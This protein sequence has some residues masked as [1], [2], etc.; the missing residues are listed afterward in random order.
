MRKSNIHLRFFVLFVL[1]CIFVMQGQKTK[2]S[3]TRITNS[4]SD[5]PV[6][7]SISKGDTHPNEKIAGNNNWL[8]HSIVGVK[9]T[10][11]KAVRYLEVKV[12]LPIAK[13]EKTEVQQISLPF[14]YGHPFSKLREMEPIKP[15]AKVDLSGFRTKCEEAKKL[16]ASIGHYSRY[17]IK[18]LKTSINLVIF[19]D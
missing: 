9:N 8:D 15:G 6:E 19:D 7:V 1:L 17:S 5:E 12:T 13:T 18:D 4:Y 3:A 10:S 16:L 11:S 2:S 14:I